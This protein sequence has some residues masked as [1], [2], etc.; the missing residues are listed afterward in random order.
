MRA[1]MCRRRSHVTRVSGQGHQ[2]LRGHVAAKPLGKYLA[3]PGA[4]LQVGGVRNR[5]LF[6]LAAREVEMLTPSQNA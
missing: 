3:V 4:D 2:V 1:C 5:C 6:V